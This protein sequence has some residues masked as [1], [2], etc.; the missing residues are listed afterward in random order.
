MLRYNPEQTPDP[1]EWIVLDEQQRIQ[2]AEKYHRGESVMPPNLKA[3]ATFHT[4]VENQ[5]AEGLPAVVRAME[6][7]ARQGLSRH[8]CIHAVG[9]VLAQHLY[10]IATARD[11]DTPEVANARYTAA[12]DRL[13]AKTW[14]EQAGAV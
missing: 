4:I 10:E 7:L 8:D 1:Q 6:R 5:I 2:L 3:H 12:V 11:A 9:W 13:D 14:R